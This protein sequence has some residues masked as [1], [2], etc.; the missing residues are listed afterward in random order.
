MQHNPREDV[1][2]DESGDVLVFAVNG[3]KI[4]VR[5]PEPEMTLLEFL[6]SNG[7]NPLG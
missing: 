6:R 7:N 1:D 5:Q 2:N 3:K 4:E